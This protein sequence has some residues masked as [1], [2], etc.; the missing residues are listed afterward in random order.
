[1]LNA[2]VLKADETNVS[3][4]RNINLIST[5]DNTVISKSVNFSNLNSNIVGKLN[6]TGNMLVCGD[7]V[8]DRYLTFNNGEIIYITEEEYE[9]YLTS[10]KITFDAN[11]G[12]VAVVDKM[13]SLNMAIGELPMPSRDYY[14]FDGWYTESAGGEKITADTIMTSL[15]DMTI[16]AHWIQNNV[17]AWT[18]APNV[19]SEAQIVNRKWIYTLTSYTTSNSSS[20]SG[21]TKYKTERT[22]WGATQGPV[23]SNPS[24]GSRNVWS[25]QYVSST[26]KHYKYYHRWNG[27]GWWGDDSSS[28][29]A[30]HTC[31][32]TYSLYTKSGWLI[33][34]VQFYGEYQCPS[35]GAKH[36]WIPNGTYTTNNYS[37]RWY[38]QDP[39]YTYYYSKTENKEA[40]A[41]PNGSNIS[42]I[43][44]YVQYRV[45]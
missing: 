37:T 40:S 42:N 4:N 34:G 2:L 17:S 31:D 9:N 41:Y 29:L 20:L 19:P 21:W 3:L 33:G 35:C 44:E 13:A 18:L 28:N 43:K 1:M 39:V 36:M 12:T 32:L 30:R 38:Y 22:S 15:T 10:H 27:N 14:T 26:T 8:G 6:I 45:K 23:Y 24:N 25:E 16:Y 5:S 11:G 7:V